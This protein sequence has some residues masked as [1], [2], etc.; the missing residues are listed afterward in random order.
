MR[1]VLLF[2]IK[3]V[4]SCAPCNVFNLPQKDPQSPLLLVVRPHPTLL[5]AP[6]HVFFCND[7]ALLQIA[8]DAV[9]LVS[10]VFSFVCVPEPPPEPPEPLVLPEPPPEL[11]LPPPPGAAS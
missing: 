9:Q 1:E 2:F 10:A 7:F 6:P 5:P 3:A 11:E 8:D 4:L